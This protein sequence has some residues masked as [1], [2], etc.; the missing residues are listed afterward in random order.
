MG[1]QNSLSRFDDLLRHLI[2][3]FVQ[4]IIQ[5]LVKLF[6]VGLIIGGWY[7]LQNGNYIIGFIVEV[8]GMAGLDLAPWVESKL[9]KERNTEY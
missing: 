4:W 2:G 1:G 6:F 8:A 9:Y 3:V 7:L 5:S